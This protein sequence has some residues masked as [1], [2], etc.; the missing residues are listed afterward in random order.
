MWLLGLLCSAMFSRFVFVLQGPLLI[1][2]VFVIDVEAV[3]V[4]CLH[5]FFFSLSQLVCFHLYMYVCL[6]LLI[7]YVCVVLIFLS[8][9]VQ[10]VYD[11]SLP[12]GSVYLG[13]ITAKWMDLLFLCSDSC[14]CINVRL[15]ADFC[16][17]AYVGYSS[18]VSVELMWKS[19]LLQGSCVSDGSVSRSLS[20]TISCLHILPSLVFWTTDLSLYIFLMLLDMSAS[21]YFD[22]LIVVVSMCCRN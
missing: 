12:N 17:F 16:L 1:F 13:W 3:D 5:P 22:S 2:F 11:E 6:L 18:S 10:Y 14:I 15:C 20:T 19:C 7:S 9:H 4:A 8:I 21:L